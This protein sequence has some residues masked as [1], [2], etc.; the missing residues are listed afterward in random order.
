MGGIVRDAIEGQP[1]MGIVGEIAQIADVPD[2]V[3][4]GECD[5]VVATLAAR[6][7]VPAAYQALLFGEHPV[8]F[9][10][11]D[12]DGR[13]LQAYARSVKRE[14]AVSDLLAVIRHIAAPDGDSPRAGSIL[15]SDAGPQHT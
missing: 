9:I 15:Q 13:R 11:L 3:S 2:S 8:P 14:F 4:R 6:S 10:V 7:R 12:S 1:D 5:V